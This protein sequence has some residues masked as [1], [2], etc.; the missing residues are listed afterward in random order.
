[1][2]YFTVA[3]CDPPCKPEGQCVRPCN[4]GEDCNN[5]CSC[6]GGLRGSQCE[7]G[8]YYIPLHCIYNN[9]I[10]EI[11]TDVNECN[12]TDHGCSNNADCINFHGGYF[13]RCKNGYRG[14]GR[15]CVGE[16]YNQI[17]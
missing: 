3:H 16:Q 17:A 5:I 4:S 7:K 11:F 6:P 14:N 12:R 9:Y 2:I 15:T 10:T 1:M 13:C 8:E